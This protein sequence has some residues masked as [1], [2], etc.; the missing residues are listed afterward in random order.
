MGRRLNRK[1]DR[2]LFGKTAL[3]VLPETGE[4]GQDHRVNDQVIEGNLRARHQVNEENQAIEGIPARPGI[5]S[6]V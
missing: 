2:I 4:N 3:P 5:E 6:D 1:T